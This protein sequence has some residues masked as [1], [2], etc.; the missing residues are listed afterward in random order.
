MLKSTFAATIALSFG[1]LNAAPALADGEI[2][3]TQAK[4]LAG[5]VTPGDPPGFPI[6]LTQP[7]KYQF[8]GNIHPP[9]NT[10]GIQVGSYN[11]TI[12]LNGFQL[13]GS[14]VALFGVA[15]ATDGV[16][17]ENGTIEGFKYDGI[18]PT[19][20]FWIVR[21]MRIVKNARNGVGH[22]NVDHLTVL[23]SMISLNGGGGVFC[24]FFCHVE[25]N[26]ISENNGIGVLITNGSVLG[27]SI[28]QNAGV[29]LTA[30]AAA[31]YGNNTIGLNN[32]TGV[33][34]SGGAA[35]HPNHC[36]GTCPP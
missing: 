29:G 13:H 32:S 3:L 8:A 25:G 36:Y 17:V 10:V 9:A 11:V 31:G 34:I 14:T 12:D 22:A 24:D 7:G 30:Y 2:L 27:N 16:T 4:A 18:Y 21:N 15:G 35:I 26:N 28:M 23:D 33:Q 1:I 19:G 5:N 20:K 6:V